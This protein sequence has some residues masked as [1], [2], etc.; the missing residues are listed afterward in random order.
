MSVTL[1]IYQNEKLSLK[2]K[3][4]FFLSFSVCLKERNIHL[5][6]LVKQ[7]LNFFY[8]ILLRKF[9]SGINASLS[10]TKNG[11]YKCSY[12]PTSGSSH[13]WQVPKKK[14]IRIWN[15]IFIRLSL[16]QISNRLYIGYRRKPHQKGYKRRITQKK[17][18]QHILTEGRHAYQCFIFPDDFISWKFMTMVRLRL[19][20]SIA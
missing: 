11:W 4:S 18:T 14:L 16:R 8:I 6:A 12:V 3:R 10:N 2:D 15:F 19:I 13:I 5:K 7:D 17:R 1:G 20:R 9:Q